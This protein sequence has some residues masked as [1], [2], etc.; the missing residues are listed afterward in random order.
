MDNR[1]VIRHII[2]Q[3][4]EVQN[5]K[6]W[7]GDNFDRKINSITEREAFT[8][9]SPS[10][11]SVAELIA[12][13]T[14]WS[15][16]T[17]L[18]IRNGTG[19]LRDNDEQNWPDNDSLKKLGWDTIVQDYRKSLSRVIDLL[20]DKDDSFLK[21]TYYDQDFKGEFEYS[22][23]IDGMLHH[24]IYHLGQMGILIKLIK[25]GRNAP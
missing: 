9:P 22:F 11:H 1:R 21:E 24:N 6:L 12:H 25:E 23:A 4:L 2:R 5:G 15:N 18:K 3:L 17:I 16:D 20:K 19:Q 10:M 7:M 8:K 14:A 13:L